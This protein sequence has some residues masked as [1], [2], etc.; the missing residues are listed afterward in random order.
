MYVDDILVTGN[1]LH[2]IQDTKMKLHK[3]FKIKDL[4]ELRYFRGIEFSRSLKGILMNQ[5]KYALELECWKTK[6]DSS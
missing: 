3:S 2:M 4:G 5:R 1:S 6:M